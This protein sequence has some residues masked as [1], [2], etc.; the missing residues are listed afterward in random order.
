MIFQQKRVK[1]EP[2]TKP[3]TPQKTWIL[4]VCAC[5]LP[6]PAARPSTFQAMEPMAWVLASRWSEKWYAFIMAV[7][8]FSVG[9]RRVFL[10]PPKNGGLWSGATKNWITKQTWH[11]QKHFGW[12][13]LGVVVFLND[14]KWCFLGKLFYEQATARSNGW[15][16]R[17][18]VSFQNDTSPLFLFL[19]SWDFCWVG[20]ND[21]VQIFCA[22]AY[23]K[24][25]M[26]H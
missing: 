2:P 11:Q 25:Q 14:W 15:I 21:R 19:L 17:I 22:Q 4:C 9:Q 8:Q 13:I 18:D 12:M 23:L 7:A 16:V 6:P 1:G 24:W 5:H 3:P 20:W 26:V 10:V